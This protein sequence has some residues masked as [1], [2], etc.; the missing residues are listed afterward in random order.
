VVRYKPA[1]AVLAWGQVSEVLF[2]SSL[3]ICPEAEFLYDIQ[4]KAVRVF[5]VVIHSHLHSFFALRF[6]FL[7]TQ[8]NSYFCS[9]VTVQ[10]T[11]KVKGGKP[12]RK[13][14]P[15]P[16]GLRNPYRNPKI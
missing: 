10:Y 7:L 11:V 14:Y 16:Y 4:T 13:P 9:S 6:I 15:L 8:S 12:D 2:L 5:L 1:E 3:N